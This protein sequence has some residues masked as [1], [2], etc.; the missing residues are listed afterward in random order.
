MIHSVEIAFLVISFT[1]LRLECEQIRQNITGLGTIDLWHEFNIRRAVLK[2]SG[3]RVFGLW[4]GPASNK[5]AMS[6]HATSQILDKRKD[7]FETLKYYFR[8]E[9]TNHRRWC[10]PEGN[11]VKSIMTVYCL[12]KKK[13][14]TL[15]CAHNRDTVH[16]SGRPIKRT[17]SI[18]LALSRVLKLM[19]SI[20]LYNEP[21]FSRHLY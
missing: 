20:S 11:L 14:M 9:T 3:S 16:L 4:G 17:P 10:R 2:A 6:L 1:R 13:Q 7:F 8:M 19:S 5:I 21:L 12:L 18:K 15:T